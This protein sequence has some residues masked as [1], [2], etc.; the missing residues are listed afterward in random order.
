MIS[1]FLLNRR[2]SDGWTFS[3][4][5]IIQIISWCYTL[6]WYILIIYSELSV[7]QTRRIEKKIGTEDRASHVFSLN[8][9]RNNSNHRLKHWSFSRKCG[10]EQSRVHGTTRKWMQYSKREL[11]H[12]QSYI[13]YLQSSFSILLRLYCLWHR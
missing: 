10:F 1:L 9:T 12:I 2:W 6:R 13:L 5:A 4:P 11:I 3:M 7:F 8:R